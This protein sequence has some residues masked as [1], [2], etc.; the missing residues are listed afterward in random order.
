MAI[1]IERKFLVADEGWRTAVSR[2]RHIRQG[3]LS[4]NGL[5]S[6]RVRCAGDDRAV[7][8]IKSAE[9]GARRQEFEY[10]IPVADAVE[11]LRL[12]EGGIVEKLRHEVPHAGLTWEVDVFLGA[13]QGL[14]IAEAELD[15]EDQ[16]IEKPAWLGEEVTGEQRFYNAGLAKRPFN[17]WQP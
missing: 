7:L 13:N 14:V 12:C 15:Y 6:V 3:Y 1:E 8:T 17:S 16:V 4:N 10:A 2:T 5:S 11:L 9:Q